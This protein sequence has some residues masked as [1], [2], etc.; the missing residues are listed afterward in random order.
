[1]QNGLKYEM[2]QTDLDLCVNFRCVRCCHHKMVLDLHILYT[3]YIYCMYKCKNIY[4]HMYGNHLLSRIF[5]ILAGK[6]SKLIHQTDPK[7][8]W[9]SSNAASLT[10]IEQYRSSA[11]GSFL[12]IKSSKPARNDMKWYEMQGFFT[13]KIWN[14]MKGCK[15]IW[16]DIQRKLGCQSSELRS[17][18]ITTIK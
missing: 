17:F 5:W 4:R 8:K 2:F 9:Y 12:Q 10:K 18:K 3:T 14:D 13:K 16:K 6:V 11:Q 1:M 7:C 15:R